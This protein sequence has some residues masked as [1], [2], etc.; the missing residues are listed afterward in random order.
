MFS[1]FEWKLSRDNK[2]TIIEV[3]KCNFASAVY[4]L[5]LLD[6]KFR[7][8]HKEEFLL[9]WSGPGINH[10]M[11]IKI[12]LPASTTGS[13]DPFTDEYIS[14]FFSGIRHFMK[15]T[16]TDEIFDLCKKLS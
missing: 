7:W 12:K 9:Q 13:K 2:E 10:E 11:K 16:G 8:T 4:L 5:K 3:W 15:D 6:Q 1:N 14:G